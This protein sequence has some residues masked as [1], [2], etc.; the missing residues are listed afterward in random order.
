VLLLCSAVVAAA[1]SPAELLAAG[2][3]DEAIAALTARTKSSPNDAEAFHLLSRAHYHMDRWDE[4]VAAGERAV[5]LQPNNSNYHLWLGR[6]YGLKAENASFISAPG[7]AGKARREFERAVQ[8]DPANAAARADLAEF[9]MEAPGIIGGGK[10]KAAAQAELLARLDAAAANWLRGKLA[11]KEK[12]HEE[13]EKQ[14]RAAIQASKSPAGRWIDLASFFRNVSRFDAMEEA[15]NK[16]VALDTG[17]SPVL[18]EAASLLFASG[19]NLGKAADYVKKYLAS[20]AQVEEAP[21][22]RAHLLLGS[23][24]EKQGQKQAAAQEY[25]AAL[26]L[27][28]DFRPAQKALQ[29]VS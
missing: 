13:A 6:A 24:Y 5:G 22:Y 3:A 14:Y 27:A 16:A 9:Y 10:D 21:A 1:A 11:E 18:F 7:L 20:S 28:R 17:P 8:L 15:I 25:R 12:N 4:A 2:R 26:A 29:R 23:I 19:R